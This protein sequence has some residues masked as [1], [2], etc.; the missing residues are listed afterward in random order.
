MGVM[1]H[2]YVNNKEAPK[3]AVVCARETLPTR[4][5]KSIFLAGPT[6]RDPGTKSWRPEALVL[7]QELGFDGHVF[8]PEDRNGGFHGDYTH[9]VQW[10]TDAL[11]MADVIVFWVPREMGTMPA[12]TTNIEWGKWADS[13]KAI[14]GAPDWAVSMRYLKWQANEYKVPLYVDLKTTLAR[15]V[16]E[17][18]PGSFREGGASRVPLLVWRHQTFQDWYRAQIGVGNRL[19]GARVLWTFRV[20]PERKRVFCWAVHVDVYV[21]AEGRNKSNEFV[22][23][24]VDVAAVVLYYRGRHMMKETDA[25]VVLVREFRS[26]ARTSDG[27]V[28]ELPA[29]GVDPN[30]SPKDTAIKEL[31]EE[32]G[33]TLNENRLRLVGTHQVAGTLSAHTAVVYAA[34]I[35]DDELDDIES[36]LHEV[37]GV[38]E[39][40]ERTTVI[41]DTLRNLY[42]GDNYDVDWATLGMISSAILSHRG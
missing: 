17:L 34:E 5:E 25:Q 7:L 33:F 36:R 3:Y 39:D 10:E 1:N 23:G 12:L 30:I 15:A 29:G 18:G 31:K 24:R 6:P 4:I 32:T 40:T 37:H 35:E 42:N 28:V 38:E 19:D 14:L 41:L 20:G 11:N 22:L 2:D 21:A 26:P 8:V 27:Y 13:G 9:Q 16:E